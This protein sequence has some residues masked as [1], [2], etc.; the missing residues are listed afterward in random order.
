[1]RE[2]DTIAFALNHITC[3]RG[4]HRDLA[5]LAS[6]LGLAAV[7]IRNDIP[8]VALADG[9]P[10]GD[11]EQALRAVAVQALSINALQRFNDWND[12]R[13]AEAEA[14]AAATRASGAGALVLCPVNQGG[15]WSVESERLG[16]LRDAL[17]ALKPILDGHG[18]IGLVEPL[19]F[20]GCSL[21]FKRDAV[22][23][24]DA[25]GG[26]DTYRLLHDTFHHA[27][28]RD[29]DMYPQR[30]G[31]VH[32]SGV[33]APDIAVSE[34]RDA[35]RVLIDDQDRIDN[36]GQIAALIR[37]GYAGHFSIECF[38]QNVQD[39]VDL[40]VELARSMALVQAR[41]AEAIDSRPF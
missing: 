41:V 40:P 28:A 9:T 12:E 22:D 1:M 21:R 2:V 11:V 15:Y 7:E 16:A 36:V 37:G 34:M 20:E 38:A 14:L 25:V 6:S 24:I 30:T 10:P 5:Q 26:A 27:I 32:I 23:A 8:G 31:L 39:S 33:S 18:V 19:G 17:A 29:P 3:A 4:G 35:H 13:A